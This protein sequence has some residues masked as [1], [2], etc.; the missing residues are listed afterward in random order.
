MCT[1]IRYG[2]RLLGL[3][4]YGPLTQRQ[5]V[6]LKAFA[7]SDAIAP[8]YDLEQI[9]LSFDDVA[10]LRNHRHLYLASTLESVV[11][12]TCFLRATWTETMTTL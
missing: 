8:N 12:C 1:H 7:E 11:L 3:H 10:V 2:A 9:I 6:G 5:Y 4:S